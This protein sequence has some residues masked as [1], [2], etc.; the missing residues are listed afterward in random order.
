MLNYDFPLNPRTRYFLRVESLAQH[1]YFEDITKVDDYRIYVALNSL[2]DFINLIANHNLKLELLQEINRAENYL[3]KNPNN[4]RRDLIRA[5]KEK[6]QKFEKR[7]EYVIREFYIPGSLSQRSE[8]GPNL[9]CDMPIL[10]HWSGQSLEKR[11][12]DF[13][14]WSLS[15][16]PAFECCLFLLEILRQTGETR[17]EEIENGILKQNLPVTNPWQMLRIALPKEVDCFPE[18]S[19]GY[20]SVNVRFATLVNE[21]IATYK[22]KIK[23]EISYYSF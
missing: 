4:E 1:I 15:V 19:T 3:Q 20:Q 11:K 9:A 13:L 10:H 8:I 22:D 6:I 5:Q 2:V 23:T 18:V 12:K 14:N 21:K 7:F 17:Y 16:K